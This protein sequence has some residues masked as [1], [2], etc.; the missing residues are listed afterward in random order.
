MV[1]LWQRSVPNFPTETS[2]AFRVCLA[3]VRHKSCFFPFFT[4]WKF[5]DR[6]VCIE[7]CLRNEIFCTGTFKVLQGAF[8]E[9]SLWKIYVYKRYKQF[10]KRRESVEGEKHSVRSSISA[11]ESHVKKI[12]DSLLQHRLLTFKNF[13]D[14][15]G[16]SN[17]SVNH[18]SKDNLAWNASNR[19]WYRKH[20][21]SALFLR[22]H[23]V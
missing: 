8:G 12:K 22:D 1:A 23:I 3:F 14:A 16:I 15:V 6:R 20:P 21:T 9:Q 4:I 10:K 18:I 17:R 2:L 19:D 13:A 11:D 7:L 5:V